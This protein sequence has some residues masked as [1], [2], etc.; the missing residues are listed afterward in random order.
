MRILERGLAKHIEQ[1]LPTLLIETM[2]Q[3]LDHICIRVAVDRVGWV[4]RKDVVDVRSGDIPPKTVHEPSGV[5]R[6]G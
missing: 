6:R 1:L 5:V 3:A 4:Y 2:A